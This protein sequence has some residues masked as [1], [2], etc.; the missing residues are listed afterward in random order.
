M[1]DPPNR[2]NLLPIRDQEYEGLEVEVDGHSFIG[3][4]FRKCRMKFRAKTPAHFERCNFE[5]CNWVLAEAAAL[6][7]DLIHGISAMGDGEFG[8]ILLVKTFPT[9]E[10]W[11]SDEA[12]AKLAALPEE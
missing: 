9:L 5:Y 6:T 2:L 11:L 1:L 7:L 3:C 4:T 8:R 12:K 10:A